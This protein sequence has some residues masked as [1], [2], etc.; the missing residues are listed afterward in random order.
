MRNYPS[1]PRDAAPRRDEIAPTS[2][3][4]AAAIG[5]AQIEIGVFF[6]NR[7]EVEQVVRDAGGRE[8][9]EDNLRWRDG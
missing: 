2:F 7:D 8:R 6:Q 1:P 4:T 3:K 9:E 5:E